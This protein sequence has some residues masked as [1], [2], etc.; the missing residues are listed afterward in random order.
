VAQ[1]SNR[2]V[3]EFNAFLG[4]GSHDEDWYNE[5]EFQIVVFFLFGDFPQSE[6]YVPTFRNALSVPSPHTTYGDGT[7][8]VPKRR[9]I[10]FRRRGITQK[11]EYNIYNTAQV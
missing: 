9:H 3:Y 2:S 7:D 1:R 4:K 6:F 8:R 5:K 11:K 10:K